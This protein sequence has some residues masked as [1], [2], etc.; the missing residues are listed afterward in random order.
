MY[1]HVQA[2]KLSTI[3]NEQLVIL[4]PSMFCFKFGYFETNFYLIKF[5]YLD[6][7]CYIL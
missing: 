5:Y 2:I 6:F 3:S 1:E 7:Q 4:G